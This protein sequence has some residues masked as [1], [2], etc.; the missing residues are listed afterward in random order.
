MFDQNFIERLAQALAAR[1]IPQIQNGNGHGSKPA[2][3]RLLTIKEAADY[4]G[5]PSASS[6]YHLVARREL[7]CVRHGRNRRF[8]V[9][10][11]DRWI[12][13]DRV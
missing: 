5:R 7:P 9:K 4:L 6:I 8:D 13:G 1:I 12:E 2:Q 10:E 3:K 11:L